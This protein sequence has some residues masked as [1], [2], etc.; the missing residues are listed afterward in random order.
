MP[1]TR[2]TC[3]FFKFT[4]EFDLDFRHDLSRDVECKRAACAGRAGHVE[5]AA[6]SDEDILRNAETQPHAFHDPL[7]LASAVEG[8][9]DLTLFLR[10][11]AWAAV[12]DMDR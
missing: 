10:R 7:S 4:E 8:L 6:M 3:K 2:E 11:D 12:C 1:K 9:E 5:L